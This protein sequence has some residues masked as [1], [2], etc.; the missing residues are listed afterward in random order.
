IGPGDLTQYFNS[1]LAFYF[2]AFE[3]A[4]GADVFELDIVLPP[5]AD[6]FELAIVLPAGADD[7]SEPS[8]AIVS[9]YLNLP[10]AGSSSKTTAGFTAFRPGS[11]EILPVTPAKSLVALMASLSFALSDA[12]PARLLA[13]ASTFAASYARAA[14]ESG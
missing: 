3:L 1:G 11:R 12:P 7:V 13:S 2:A 8:G 4:A 14:S 10:A 9:L 5:G 6:V